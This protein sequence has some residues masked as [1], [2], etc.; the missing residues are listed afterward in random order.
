MPSPAAAAPDTPLAGRHALITGGGKGI[1]AAIAIALAARGARLSL[2]G[3]EMAALKATAAALPHALPLGADVTDPAATEAA[4]TQ[5]RATHGPI[6]ILVNNAGAVE[7]APLTRTDDALWGRLIELNLGAVF[8][9]TRAVLPEMLAAGW[10]RVIN[11]ASTAGLTGYPY[12]AAYCAAKH[13]VVGLTRA[14]ALETAGTGVT[15]NCVCPGLTDTALAERAVAS[16]AARTGRPEAE[17]RARLIEPN[18][19][20]RLIAPQE[21]AETVAWLA[22]PAA[23]AMTGQAIAV[24]GGEVMP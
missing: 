22:L 6:H 11:I 21:V 19:L 4:L 1:G 14:V 20:G 17:I 9:L 13:G 16:V 15:V 5:A 23:S 12:V 3:R 10:G 24:A 7:T 18:P 8:R 2:L